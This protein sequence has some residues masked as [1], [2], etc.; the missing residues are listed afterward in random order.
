MKFQ[1]TW[2]H[3]DGATVKIVEEVEADVPM[4]PGDRFFAGQSY[5]VLSSEIFID[6][7]V[8]NRRIMLKKY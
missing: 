6:K 2:I 4:S 8:V 7:G 5:V 1:T 3:S